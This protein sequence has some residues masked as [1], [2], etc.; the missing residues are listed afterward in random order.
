VYTLNLGYNFF[1]ISTKFRCYPPFSLILF[2]FSLNSGECL[3]FISICKH[4]KINTRG[5]FVVPSCRSIFYL[6][7]D[8]VEHVFNKKFDLNW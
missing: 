4:G 2:S 5:G 8:F 3:Y 1:V 7:S 6:M